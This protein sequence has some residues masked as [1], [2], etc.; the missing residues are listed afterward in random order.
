VLVS[1]QLICASSPLDAPDSHRESV[2]TRT[3]VR[4]S[5][6]RSYVDQFPPETDQSQ[7][8]AS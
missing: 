2:D 6:K 1:W 7:Q 3:G 4:Y 5:N 8:A